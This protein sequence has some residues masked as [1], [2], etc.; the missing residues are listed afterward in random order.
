MGLEVAV[1]STA[2]VPAGLID[3]SSGVHV[4]PQ[5]SLRRAK[6]WLLRAGPDL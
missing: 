5:G 2:W 6:R 1:H 3:G 4:E